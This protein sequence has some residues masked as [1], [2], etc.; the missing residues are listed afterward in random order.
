M[1]KADHL[2]R[3]LGMR[4]DSD[5]AS[6]G[7]AVG[8][9]PL[10]AAKIIEVGRIIADPDQPRRTFPDDEIQQLADSLR[11][12]GQQEPVTVR[13]D[14]GRDRYVLIAGERRW[15]AA[16][17]ATLP[18]LN[19]IVDGRDL[20]P[21]RLLEMQVVENVQRADLTVLE[22]G[23]AYRQLLAFWNCTQQE[24]AERLHVSQA[25]VSRAIAALDL[26]TDV[27]RDVA[28]GKVAAAKALQAAPRKRQRKQAKPSKPVRLSCSAGSAVVTVKAG[29]SVADVLAALLEQERNRKAA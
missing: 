8:V 13:W 26:P 18:T 28:T 27:Q 17:L 5:A 7:K 19:A 9:Q 4:L 2:T 1:G 10:T 14:A 11:N 20:A 22:A 12:H 3:L 16:Q 21:D 15:R 24:L 6:A 29:S 23:A 25:R